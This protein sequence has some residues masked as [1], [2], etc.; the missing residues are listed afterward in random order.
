MSNPLLRITTP[1]GTAFQYRDKN[2]EVK[3]KVEWAPSFG[4]DWTSHLSAVQAKFDTETLR[5]T[6]KYV[7][8]Q[9]GML[10]RSAQLASDIGSGE[11][12]WNTPYAARQYYCTARN[13]SYSATAG[14]YWGERMKA[15]NLNYLADFA[16]KAVGKK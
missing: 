3:V 15:D 6:D 13:R 16:R 4:G 12:V 10:R 8:M 14:A 2:S 9:T 11:L 5:I 7:P 1:R